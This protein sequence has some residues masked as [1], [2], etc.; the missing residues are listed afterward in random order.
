MR[1]LLDI[2]TEFNEYLNQTLPNRNDLEKGIRYAML[3]GGSRF[4]PLLFLTIIETFGLDASR[5]FSIALAIEMV[6]ASSLV[7]DDLPEMDNDEIRRGIPTV[8]KAFGHPQALLIGDAMLANSFQYIATNKLLLETEKV[9]LIRALSEAAGS[10]GLV[11]GQ[12]NELAS[13]KPTLDELNAI[14]H[15]KTGKMFELSVR[16]AMIVANR[17]G[18]NGEWLYFS[19][20]LGV[21][22]Q[23]KD[24]FM[25]FKENH[26]LKI[27][28]YVSIVGVDRTK[29]I[30]REKRES[31]FTLVKQL[32][33]NG[34][35]LKDLIETMFM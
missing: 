14:H 20:L 9:N 32:D 28:T 22:Y 19:S 27:E 8:H 16:A 13:E 24:D 4:R 7:H 10:E 35:L 5:Y 33:S 2:K 25:D 26:D 23:I 6:H 21:L 12:Y 30:Y 18:N 34:S 29:E 17:R 31:L 1:T 3:E 11:L 15:L